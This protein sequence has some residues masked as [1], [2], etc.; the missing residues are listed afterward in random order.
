MRRVKLSR[1]ADA[2]LVSILDYGAEQF[3]WGSAADYVSSFEASFAM[4][5]DHPE[6][7]A[8]HPDIHPPIRSAAHR[9]HRIFYD[10]EESTIVIQRILHKAMDVRRWMA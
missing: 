5:C 8:I 4:L 10:V 1:A 3:G 6:I 9:S 2:D 7:G